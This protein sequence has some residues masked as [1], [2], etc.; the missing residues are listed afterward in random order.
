MKAPV[1]L[2]TLI[3]RVLTPALLGLTALWGCFVYFSIRQTIIDGFDRKLLAISGATA[4][5]LDAEVH[6]S[7]Q[8]R[9]T[10]TAL[11]TGPDGQLLGWDAD[12]RDLVAIDTTAGGATPLGLRT[13][14]P[15]RALAFDSGRGRLLALA[16]DGRRLEQFVITPPQ[17]LPELVLATGV[18][19][20][21]A[22]VGHLAAW[23]GRTVLRV[24]P[25]NG[26]CAPLPWT[27]PEPMSALCRAGAGAELFA[28]TTDGAA[29]LTLAADGRVLRRQSLVAGDTEDAAPPRLHAIAATGGALYAAGPALATI[30]PH[31]GSVD[32]SGT[33]LGYLSEQAPF[34]RRYR[35]P[36]IAIRN[37]AH[38]TYLYTYVYL[39]DDRIY[40]VLDATEGEGHSLPGAEDRLPTP[41]SIEG[42]RRSQFLAQ[43]WVSPLQQWEQ[44]GL[45]KTSSFPITTADGRTVALAGADVDGGVIREK[46]RWALFAVHFVGAGSL[47][48]GGLVSLLVTRSLVRPLREVKETALRIAAGYFHRSQNVGD[49]RGETSRL[50]GLLNVLAQRLE[51]EAQ[52][53]RA[54]Q[55]SLHSRRRQ[56]TLARALEGLVERDTQRS[57]TAA[58]SADQFADQCRTAAAELSWRGTAPPDAVALACWR[59]R[60]GRLGRTLLASPLAPAEI[61]AA[62]LAAAPVLLACACRQTTPPCLHY[63]TRG[64]TRLR[65]G[66]EIRILEGNGRLELVAGDALE[67][68]PGEPAVPSLPDHRTASPSP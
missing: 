61:P 44:W 42:A 23:S 20:I 22:D 26:A 36:F 60:L 35:E 37:A 57:P 41:A 39:G 11:C 51:E 47:L 54:Y 62:M 12:T 8:R 24:A 5:F 65:L 10:I 46:T 15:V 50:S 2:Q 1:P 59:A 34:Y 14:G 66:A 9:R 58:A 45:V 4:A 21:F 13:A 3:L 63:S 52:R 32:W 40:Y 17:P 48:A 31:D 68:L 56:T 28:I 19:G 18:D 67:W 38:L 30:A 49:A 6:A 7:F 29:L 16:A 53:S 55:A 64:R 25:E 33:A 43:P 27:L